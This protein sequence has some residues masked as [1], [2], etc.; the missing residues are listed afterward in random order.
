[1]TLGWPAVDARLRP[2]LPLSE[3][4][5][6]EFYDQQEPREAL[7]EYDEIMRATG[8]YHGRQVEQPGSDSEYEEYGWLEH[9]ARRV[10]RPRR[11]RLRQYINKQGFNLE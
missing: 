11:V 10:S 1:M 8:I 3:V 6:W 9:S 7:A 4:L 5:H 2:R